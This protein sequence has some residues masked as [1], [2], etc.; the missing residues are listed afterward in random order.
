MKILIFDQALSFGKIIFVEL[1]RFSNKV[2]FIISDLQLNRPI[3]EKTSC[4]GH[5]GREEFPWEV[6]KELNL[7]SVKQAING[8]YNGNGNANGNCNYH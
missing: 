2:F 3:Y 5:F 1:Y 6:P 8:S 4:Y 7:K